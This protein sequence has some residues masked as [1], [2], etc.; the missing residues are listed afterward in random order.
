MPHDFQMAGKPGIRN[1]HGMR[2]RQKGGLAAP[3]PSPAAA[4]GTLQELVPRFLQGM[5]IRGY[6]AATAEM[7]YSALRQFLGWCEGLAY[8]DPAGF[9]RGRLE[10]YQLFLFHYRSPR[11]GKTLA[12][13]T[14]L[15]RLGCIRRFF[16]W[17]CRDGVIPANPASDLDLPRKQ[18]RT[19]PKSLSPAEIDRL[20]ALPDV[21]SPFG[22]A[23]NLLC[24][25]GP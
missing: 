7:H 14:Q 9:T 22:A 3:A 18:A 2:G 24:A 10:A 4:P 11:G 12:I 20:L 1:L 6:S 19:L 5:E 25:G 8:S 23:R 17:L 15:A 21:T 13:N 16:A